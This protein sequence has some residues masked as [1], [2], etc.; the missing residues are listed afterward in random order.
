MIQDGIKQGVRHFEFGNGDLY[1][2]SRACREPV[3]KAVAERIWQCRITSLGEVPQ[4][5]ERIVSR[6]TPDQPPVNAGV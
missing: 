5:K 3:W 1:Y 4:V 6:N 2:K